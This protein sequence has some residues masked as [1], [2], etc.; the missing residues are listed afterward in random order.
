VNHGQDKL[1]RAQIRIVVGIQIIAGIPLPNQR[2]G[3]SQI[4]IELA[5]DSA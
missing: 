2:L 5:A 4:Q 1:K 3:R